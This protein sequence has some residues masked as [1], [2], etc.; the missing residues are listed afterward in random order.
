MYQRETITWKKRK[1]EAV[2]IY[3]EMLAMQAVLFALIS[4]IEQLH[5]VG[6]R[7]LLRRRVESIIQRSPDDVFVSR[8]ASEGRALALDLIRRLVGSQ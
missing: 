3:A 4:E 5:G 7:Q 2:A 1:P 6:L 8:Y